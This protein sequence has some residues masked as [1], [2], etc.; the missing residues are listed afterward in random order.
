[1]IKNILY[2]ILIYVVKKYFIKISFI[3]E[4]RVIFFGMVLDYCCCID[5]FYFYI[6]KDYNLFFF[7]FKNE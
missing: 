4:N 1:M 2:V 3:F 5:E 7:N 6:I